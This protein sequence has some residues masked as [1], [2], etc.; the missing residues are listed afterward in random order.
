MI[1]YLVDLLYLS[2]GTCCR[3]W[4]AAEEE[5][6]DSVYTLSGLYAA[7]EEEEIDRGIW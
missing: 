3:I 5:K 6:V 1:K 2:R 4:F 7:V